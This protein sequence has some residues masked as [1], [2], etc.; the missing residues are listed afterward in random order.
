MNELLRPEENRSYLQDREILRNSYSRRDLRRTPAKKGVIGQYAQDFEIWSDSWRDTFSNA[1]LGS[2]VVAGLTVAAVA[3]PLNVALAVACGLPASAGL[4]AGAVGGAIAAI[5]GGAPL[6]VTGP[7]AALNILVFALV[8]K[9][10]MAGAAAGAIAVGVFQLIFF[11]ARAGSLARFV[12]ESVLGGFVTGVGL[13]LLDQQI[14]M[15]LD[16]DHQVSELFFSLAAP[17]WLSDVNWFAVLAGLFVILFM[18][19]LAR[20]KKFPAAIVGLTLATAIS[21]YLNWDVHRVGAVPATLPVFSLPE[22]SLMQWL[23]LFVACIPL[24]ILATAESLLSAQAVDRMMPNEKPHAPNLETLGQGLANLGAGFFGGLT[25]SGVIVRSSVNVQS[26]GRSRLSSLTH[27]TILLVA[28]LFAA[29]WIGSIPVAALAGLLC[30]IGFRLIDFETMKHLLL[31]NRVQFLAFVLAAAGVVSGHLSLGLIA[32]GVISALDIWWKKR[33]SLQ[34]QARQASKT[35]AALAPGI[36]AHLPASR[37]DHFQKP[38]PAMFAAPEEDWQTHVESDPIVHPTAFVHPNASVIGHVVLGPR[39]H[40][41]SEAA[42]RADEG[43]PFFVGSDTNIQDGVVLHALKSQWVQVGEKKW[44][45]YVGERVSLA[46]QALIHGPC[47]IG[48]DTFVGFKAVVHNAVI[49]S[50]C[51]VGI[52]AIVVGVEIPDGKFVPPGS[53]VDSQEKAQALPPAEAH[54][55][56]FNEDVV[57]VNL[58]LASAYKGDGTYI[59]KPRL[60]VLKF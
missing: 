11:A 42:L 2:D 40:V 43:T 35:G 9:F 20:Y 33:V 51:S 19:G 38:T 16:V 52:G 48:D 56:H 39:V 23:N 25:V 3:L 60:E 58:G 30:L 59:P 37:I 12:P 5:F 17:V 18:L 8:S 53:L 15:L 29:V 6:Q 31:E 28:P 46:H 24:A 36:R 21:T 1:R 4:I 50:H 55:H 54:H 44:A 32:A 34:R 22:L 13:K 49:G 10:G 45:I 27:A 14:P 57:G 26:G 7:A 47:F 41:A